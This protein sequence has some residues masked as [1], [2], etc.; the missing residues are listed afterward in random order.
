[1]GVGPVIGTVTVTVVGVPTVMKAGVALTVP[2]VGVLVVW[3]SAVFATL[4]VCVGG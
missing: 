3:I 2:T 4:D 1:M